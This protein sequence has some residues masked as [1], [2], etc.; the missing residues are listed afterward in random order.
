MRAIKS[1][2]WTKR[3]RECV[4]G[5]TGVPRTGLGGFDGLVIVSVLELAVQTGVSLVQLV[6]GNRHDVQL[7]V[8]R[9]V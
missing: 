1:I 6:S 7:R 9:G 4:E 8:T 5:V 2:R 3:M